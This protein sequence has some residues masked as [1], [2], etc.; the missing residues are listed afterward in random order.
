MFYLFLSFFILND[1]FSMSRHYCSYLR[2]KR[3]KLIDKY[4]YGW[5]IAVHSIIDIGSIIG[6]MVYY[7]PKHLPIVIA[8]LVVLVVWYAPMFFK[9]LWKRW[10][11]LS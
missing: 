4:S 7:E 6:M 5:Y 3:Q 9:Y 8:I 10:N 1:G 11:A 2:D